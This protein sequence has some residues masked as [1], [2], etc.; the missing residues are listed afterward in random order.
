MLYLVNHPIFLQT[1]IHFI[2]PFVWSLLSSSVLT[3]VEKNSPKN[4]LLQSQ[5]AAIA[6]KVASATSEHNRLCM[7][8]TEVSWD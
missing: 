4:T 1:L 2:L 8:V 6:I 5:S 3:Y 7:H